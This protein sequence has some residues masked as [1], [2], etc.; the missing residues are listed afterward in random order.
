MQPGR[1]KLLEF[2]IIGGRIQK[3]LKCKN[4]KFISF[5]LEV[6][7]QKYKVEMSKAKNNNYNDYSGADFLISQKCCKYKI[8]N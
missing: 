7:K 5:F 6:E 8:Y 1:N 3:T 4:R 2:G